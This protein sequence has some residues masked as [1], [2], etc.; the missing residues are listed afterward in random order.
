MSLQRTLKLFTAIA[1]IAVLSACS[2]GQAESEGAQQAQQPPAPSVTVAKVLHE[3]L[4]E[5][6]EFTGRL[7]APESVELRPRV[8]GYIERVAFEE[9]AIV[10]AGDPL[11]YID[12]RSFNTEV[13]RLKA[14]LT[15]A[16]SQLKLADIAYNRTKRLTSQNALSKEDYDNRFAEL[17]QARAHV[18]SVEAALELAQLNLSYTQVEAPI[19]G[20]VSRADVTKGN[21]VA[22]GQTILTTL[23]STEKVYAYFDA[24]ENTYLKYTKLAQEGTRA[25]DRE[26]QNPVFM[27]LSNESEYPHQ[28]FIDFVDNRINPATGTIRGRAVFEN[29]QGTFTP[30]LFARLQLIGSAS[31]QGILIDDKAIGT[32]L[33]NKFVLVLD[34]SNTVQYRPVTLG[35]KVNGLRIIADGLNPG[36][37]IVIKGLQRVRPGTPVNPQEAEMATPE[38]L[39]TLQRVQAKVDRVLLAN[40]TKKSSEQLLTARVQ[41]SLN[42][43]KATNEGHL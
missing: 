11:F 25:D 10:Q 9:G 36:E 8:S 26:A 5:W 13:K 1:S 14:E 31:Y 29:S 3:R 12:S 22:A 17:Q 24:D 16:Q 39:A 2:Q 7:E 41:S 30:G 23:V 35:E 21:Y 27:A 40:E 33:N 18:Q 38:Q 6:D 19:T 34:Q 15:E 28:G 37:R 4:T 32:D 42:D 43:Q 20:R